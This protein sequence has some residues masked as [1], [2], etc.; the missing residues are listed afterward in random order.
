ML[1]PGGEVGS[2][3]EG[4]VD[5]GKGCTCSSKLAPAEVWQRGR[6]GSL[7]SGRQSRDGCRCGVIVE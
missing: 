4:G 5:E 6:V 3:R 7:V 2:Q 1:R